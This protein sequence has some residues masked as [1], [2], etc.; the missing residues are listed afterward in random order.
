MENHFMLRRFNKGFDQATQDRL[1]AKADRLSPKGQKKLNDT[2]SD[3]HTIL[4][5]KPVDVRVSMIDEFI[6]KILKVYPI[7]CDESKNLYTESVKKRVVQVDKKT[8]KAVAVH[9]SVRAA[10]KATGVYHG[11]ICNCCQNMECRQKG[12]PLKFKG[13]LSSK[14]YLWY[15]ETT[16][17]AMQSANQET[18][19]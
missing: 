15:F 6:D 11:T 16:W 4:V 18:K 13:Y 1:L 12:E 17:N 5:R 2:L 7:G 9:E 3:Y 19:E 10:W 8:G 14:D